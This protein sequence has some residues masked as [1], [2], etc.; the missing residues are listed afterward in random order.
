[1][2]LDVVAADNEVDELGHVVDVEFLLDA[3]VRLVG[4]DADFGARGLDGAQG[5]NGAGEE[6]V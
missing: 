1:M 2:A 6:V 5:L 3:A 4:D